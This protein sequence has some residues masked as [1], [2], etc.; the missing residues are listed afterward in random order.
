MQHTD[1]TLLGFETLAL[2]ILSLAFGAGLLRI[3]DVL[4]GEDI[5]C[6]SNCHIDVKKKIEEEEQ[7]NLDQIIKGRGY[8]YNADA[9]T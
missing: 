7:A 5:S 1:S 9:S 4:F 6:G 8:S 2:F 3:R